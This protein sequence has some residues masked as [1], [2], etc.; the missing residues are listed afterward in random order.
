MITKNAFLTPFTDD[1]T[2]AMPFAGA[3]ELLASILLN[4]VI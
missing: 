3:V 1:L 4:T 2:G